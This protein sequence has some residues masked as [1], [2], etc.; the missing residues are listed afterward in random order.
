MYISRKGFARGTFEY[1]REINLREYSNECMVSAEER[2]VSGT[3]IL[4]FAQ[5]IQ[6][7]LS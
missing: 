7:I 2:D 5:Q 1:S 4:Y 6:E 3:L